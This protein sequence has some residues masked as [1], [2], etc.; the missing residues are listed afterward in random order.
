MDGLDRREFIRTGALLAAVAG[1]G[2]PRLGGPA[3]ASAAAGSALTPHRRS[4]YRALLTVLREAPDGRFRHREA[5][6]GTRAFANWYAVQAPELRAHADSVLDAVDELLGARGD[7]PG[8]YAGL[9]D[10]PGG[11]SPAPRE[12]HRRAV[13]MAALALAEGPE[14]AGPERAPTEW[15]A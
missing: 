10:R 6:E 12:A 15:L 3:A 14:A 1:A 8:R 4:T 13:L 11:G 5:V 2:L 9:R 7:A